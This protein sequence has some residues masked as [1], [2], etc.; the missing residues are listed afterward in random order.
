M[1]RAAL[2]DFFQPPTLTFD[3]FDQSQCLG[4]HFE[5]LIHICLD[6]EGRGHGI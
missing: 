2:A 6:P 3:I 4:L 1:P 5:D